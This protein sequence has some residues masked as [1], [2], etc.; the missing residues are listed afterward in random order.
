MESLHSLPFRPVRRICFARCPLAYC[1]EP[2][3]NDDI[4]SSQS[5]SP[6]GMLHIRPEELLDLRIDLSLPLSTLSTL[7]PA[8]SL[9]SQHFARRHEHASRIASQTPH[10][11]R[12]HCRHAQQVLEIGHVRSQLSKLGVKVV[13]LSRLVG[14]A[15]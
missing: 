11:F 7:L 3:L 6:A 2:A 5:S 4:A 13:E 10:P 9:L 12:L 8:H 15:G 14:V 1:V